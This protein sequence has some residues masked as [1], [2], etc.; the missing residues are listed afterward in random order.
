MSGPQIIEEVTLP[1]G[2]TQFTIDWPKRDSRMVQTTRLSRQEVL[3]QLT[4]QARREEKIREVAQSTYLRAHHGKK[5]KEYIKKHNALEPH[6][7]MDCQQVITNRTRLAKRC[8]PCEASAR[9][10]RQAKYQENAR[11]RK[12]VEMQA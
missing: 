2:L 1:N 11:E 7:C 10:K 3:T 5:D 12:R 8:I 6:I 4:Q 9:K